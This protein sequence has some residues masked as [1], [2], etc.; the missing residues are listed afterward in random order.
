MELDKRLIPPN[1]CTYSGQSIADARLTFPD[2][3]MWNCKAF[4][5]LLTRIDSVEL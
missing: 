3:D 4:G 2:Q 5:F 1:V